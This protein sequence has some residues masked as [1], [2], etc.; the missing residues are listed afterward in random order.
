M[1]RFRR[2]APGATAL[3]LGA[4]LLGA[5]GSG[6]GGTSS[7][8]GG[9][10]VAEQFVL[11]GPPECPKQ[12]YCLPG[13]KK[14]YGL[15]F[16][17]FVPLDVGG[18]QTVAAVRS[19]KADIG[20][21]FSIDPAIAQNDFVPLED[22]K[23]L[24]AAGNIVPV[25]RKDVASPEIAKLL[26]MASAKMTND[27]LIDL[28][29]QV[30][31]EHEDV[32]QVAQSFA[33]DEGLLDGVSQTGSGSIKIGVSGAFPENQVEA[34]IY[35]SVLEAAGYDVETELNL[36]SRDVSDQA[37]FSGDIDMKP[38]YVAYELGTLDPKANASGT[39]Q[40]VLPR[41][42]KAYA[43]K[44]VEVLEPTPA[45]STN[46]FVVTKQTAEQYGLETMSDLAKPAS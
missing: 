14:T 5:C 21:L 39:A 35:A 26:N 1:R 7:G 12:P 24:Q 10:T 2:L 19:G 42:K 32:D 27:K 16:E 28:V 44:G 3:A 29:G 11:G 38:E 41:L 23:A 20:E 18:P 17:K 30:S 33:E 15:E 46:V 31:V 4:L 8:G 34:S 36:Q 40:E 13:L 37:L 6:G 43:K 25:L 45:N 22:D 9:E